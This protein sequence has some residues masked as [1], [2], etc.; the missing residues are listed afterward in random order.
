MRRIF[1]GTANLQIVCAPL[2]IVLFVLTWNRQAV[3][4][5][6]QTLWNNTI[7]KNPRPGWPT[8]ISAIF[9]CCAE[10]SMMPSS[11]ISTLWI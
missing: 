10:T 6:A 5:D 8:T 2:L 4:S 1:L 9:T 3:Y 7:A 11:N